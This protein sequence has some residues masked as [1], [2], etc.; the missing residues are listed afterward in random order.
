VTAEGLRSEQAHRRPL[1]ELHTQ[2]GDA[3][4][5]G[6][7]LRVMQVAV[8]SIFRVLFRVKVSG[9]NNLPG[10]PVIAC[11]NHL[12]WADP[13]LVLLFYPIE[14]RI[15]VLADH[16]AV[17]RTGFRATMM[18]LL[19]VVV[20]VSP[21]SGYRALREMEDVL[22]RGGSLLIVPE[23]APP[24]DVREGE[25]RPLKG[26]AAHLAMMSGTPLVPIGIAGTSELW[27][28]RR[29]AMRV[30]KPIDPA[31][32]HGTPRDRARALNDRL[33]GDIA[34]LLPKVKQPGGPRL[35]RKWLTNLFA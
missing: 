26:G 7:F 33:T 3:A 21:D 1:P 31:G 12:G 16:N 27:L 32:L 25:L 9:L 24:P 4:R 35:L 20:T 28:G 10:R 6:L 34:A 18:R 2:A 29:L 5:A 8:R 23:G 19:K 22:K 14:P 11:G 13:F 15:Y 30:G 17:G